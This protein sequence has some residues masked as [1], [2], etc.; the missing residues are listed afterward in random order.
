MLIAPKATEF[1]PKAS[2]PCNDAAMRLIGGWEWPIRKR[3]W[4]DLATEYR[5]LVEQIPQLAP[6]LAVI[7]SVIENQMADRLAATT[8]LRDLVVTTSPASEPPIDVIIVRSAISMYPPAPGEVSIDHI[9]TSGLTEHIARPVD[10]VL[11]LFWR[12]V[13][14]KYGL[15]TDHP[16]ARPE[17]S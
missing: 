4:A 14:E 13:L 5:E 7:E 6:M 12:F 15:R 3:P 9:A 2:A 10:E 16:D 1:R 8:S 11:P 17:S